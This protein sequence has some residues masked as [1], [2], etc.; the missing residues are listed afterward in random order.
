MF[1]LS[2][3]PSSLDTETNTVIA[4]NDRVRLFPGAHL[5]LKELST[6]ERF[7]DTRVAVASSTSRV[8]WASTCLSL[9][10]VR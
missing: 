9:L 1:E 10:E 8:E 4:G 5:A 7:S 3:A 2:E 6:D